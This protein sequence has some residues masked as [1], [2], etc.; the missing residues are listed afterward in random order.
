MLKRLSKRNKQISFSVSLLACLAAVWIL[1]KLFL[2]PVSS[3]IYFGIL[4]VVALAVLVL[5]ALIVAF[6]IH[7]IKKRKNDGVSSLDNDSFWDE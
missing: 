4:L 6:L 3:L 7:S 1:H 2:F 5:L